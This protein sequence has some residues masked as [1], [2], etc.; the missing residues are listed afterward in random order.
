MKRTVHKLSIHKWSVSTGCPEIFINNLAMDMK[1]QITEHKVHFIRTLNNNQ[2]VSAME[3]AGIGTSCTSL[4]LSVLE[5]PIESTVELD[6]EE[7]NRPPKS[8]LARSFPSLTLRGSDFVTENKRTSRRKYRIISWK[9]LSSYSSDKIYYIF[10][11][12]LYLLVL[13]VRKSLFKT[14]VVLVLCLCNHS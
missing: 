8:M 3:L 2:N 5:P 13:I 1:T 7:L 14:K 11:H 4:G 9:V 12:F 6:E 10:P